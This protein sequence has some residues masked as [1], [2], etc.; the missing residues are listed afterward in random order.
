MLEQ[1]P[2]RICGP[3]RGPHKT[4]GFLEGHVTHGGPMLEQFISEGLY[5]AGR[6]HANVVLEELQPTGRI[7]I[8][9]AHEGLSHGR[10]SEA[11]E[12]HEEEGVTETKR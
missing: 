4:A 9:G 3:C 11:G 12:E 10:D 5:P 7:H 8:G 6:T 1:A 2:G